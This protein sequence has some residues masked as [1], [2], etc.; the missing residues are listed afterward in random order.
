MRCR[1]IDFCKSLI[2]EKLVYL[3]ITPFG[4][5]VGLIGQLLASLVESKHQ[6]FHRLG[7][8]RQLITINQLFSVHF[9][10]SR[11]M[12]QHRPSARQQ[13]VA[14]N[15][16]NATKNQQTNYTWSIILICRGGQN[17]QDFDQSW[18]NGG[19]NLQFE[20]VFWS[21]LFLKVVKKSKII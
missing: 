1:A 3:L 18:K 11:L 15:Y 12:K 8:T 16:T 2:R 10:R 21:T 13:T 14:I 9:I 5:L 6:L 20:V 17:T 7:T 4:N 19:R